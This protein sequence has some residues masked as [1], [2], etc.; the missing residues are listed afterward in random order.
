MIQ[1]EL[2]SVKPAEKP[3]ITTSVLESVSKTIKKTPESCSF[4][5]KQIIHTD[6]NSFVAAAHMAFDQH[7]PLVL[8]PDIIWVS[9]AQGLANH[10]NMNAEELRH[11]FVNFEGKKYIEIQR[12]SFIKGNP[13][14]DWQGCFPEF[15]DKISEYI[16]KKRDLIVSNFS[17]TGPIE[18]AT[19]ELV[20]M[21]AMQSYFD[22][23]CRTCC[24]IP[25]IT[26]EGTTKDWLNIKTRIENISEF[27]LEWWTKHLL[28]I[29]DNFIDASKGNINKPFW[30]SI[31]KLGGGSGGPFI[32][33]WIAA[34]IPYLQGW[35]Q[36]INENGL[37][38]RDLRLDYK[39]GLYDYSGSYITHDNLPS[40]LSKVAF[41]WIYHTVEY[42]MDFI[43]G[44][45]GVE[46]GEDL[47]LKPC[48][49]WA[50]CDRI[51]NDL[52]YE[53]PVKRSSE[54]VYN[55]DP[56]GSGIGIIMNPRGLAIKPLIKVK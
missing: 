40:S 1:F 18:K 27:N 14:N 26:I 29:I 13:D 53:K 51:E 28:P 34:F 38:K 11:H 4:H 43:G 35:G 25:N 49:G 21:D 22:Y 23:G 24:G 7:R 12:D 36:K 52:K 10:I 46:Q 32:T 8:N 48:F 41:K 15:S 3:L 39:S 37:L 9:I 55:I 42:P 30:E 20:L 16:G 19:S 5:D 33:G 31:Y 54:P 2:T 6:Y 50:V 47:S 17:T 44:M 45:I 56:S